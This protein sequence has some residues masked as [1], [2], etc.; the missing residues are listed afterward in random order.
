MTHYRANGTPAEAVFLAL[1]GFGGVTL[2]LASPP[3]RADRAQ[4]RSRL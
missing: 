3:F 4:V 1:A 2:A